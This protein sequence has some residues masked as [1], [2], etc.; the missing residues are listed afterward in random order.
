MNFQASFKPDETFKTTTQ[1]DIPKIEERQEKFHLRQNN[2]T[3]NE[4]ALKEYRERWTTG[5]HNFGRTYLGTE[6][7]WKI[8]VLTKFSYLNFIFV[9]NTLHF[10]FGGLDGVRQRPLI[11]LEAS[12]A[13]PM[14]TSFLCFLARPMVFKINGLSLIK[15]LPVIVNMVK[16]CWGPQH[17]GAASQHRAPVLK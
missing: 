8:K 15:W 12:L 17:L 2:L 13:I 1:Q 4:Q 11:L 3:K 6:K 10:G 9:I 16:V 14:L 5:N 7:N